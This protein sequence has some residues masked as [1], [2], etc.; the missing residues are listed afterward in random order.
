M[1]CTFSCTFLKTFRQ[2]ILNDLQMARLSCGRVIWLLPMHP[3]P[4]ST[5]P[6]PPS[7]LPPP[8]VST[9]A[10]TR[11]NSEKERQ[12]ADGRGWTRSQFIRPQ[13]SLVL[14]KLFNALRFPPTH[15][16]HQPYA[17][18]KESGSFSIKIKIE[19]HELT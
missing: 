18:V 10:G 4:N 7:Q 16:F 12:H 3:T 14:Y 2:R 13:E 8:A 1:P 17:K 6:P 11:S 9:R 5:P 19:I 15:T